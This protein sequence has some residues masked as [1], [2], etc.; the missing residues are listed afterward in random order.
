LKRK[1]AGFL[2]GGYW[3]NNK[4][5]W[6]REDEWNKG[7]TGKD[8]VGRIVQELMSFMRGTRERIDRI[9]G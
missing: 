7:A 1:G 3:E 5:S 8:A 4:R 2:W 6:G 9:E